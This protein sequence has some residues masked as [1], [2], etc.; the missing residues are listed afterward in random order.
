[1]I[2]NESTKAS[3]KDISVESIKA[4]REEIRNPATGSNHHLRKLALAL[5]DELESS[6]EHVASIMAMSRD[7][8][9]VA[10]GKN[11][12][13]D[14]LREQSAEWE[15]KATS[16]FEECARMSQRIE[17]LE[18]YRT[19]FTVWHDKTEWV[20]NDKRFDVVR[21]LGKHRADVLREYIEHLERRKA[22]AEPVAYMVAGRLL[23][24]MTQAIA[25]KA[26]SDFEIKPLYVATLQPLTDTER[27]ELQERRKAGEWIPVST[28]PNDHRVVYCWSEKSEVGVEARY[29]HKEWIACHDDEEDEEENF[30][31]WIELPKGPTL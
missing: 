16:N 5:L 31:H 23:E 28:P 9:E 12:Q 21:P 14:A 11:E 15:R 25:F 30:T 8:M 6:R 27:A 3:C 29:R 10:S 13:I 7:V 17:E 24:N 1:M 26:D 2:K 18:R 4:L 19:A 20:Q 22:D